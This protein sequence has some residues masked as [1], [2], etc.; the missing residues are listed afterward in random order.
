MYDFFKNKDWFG[1]FLVF[2]CFAI[3][4]NAILIFLNPTFEKIALERT[5]LSIKP[6]WKWSLL[7]STPVM[8]SFNHHLHIEEVGPEGSEV[9]LDTHAGHFPTSILHY[10]LIRQDAYRDLNKKYEIQIL[11]SYRQV[12]L[13]KNLELKLLKCSKKQDNCYEIVEK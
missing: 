11:S 2:L 9:I 8:F 12:K 13:E 3:G 1:A 7:Q 6:F 4:L 5:Q 10:P